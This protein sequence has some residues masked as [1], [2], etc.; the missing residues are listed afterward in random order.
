M[1]TDK[2]TCTLDFNHLSSVFIFPDL[3]QNKKFNSCIGW[4][5]FPSNLLTIVVDLIDFNRDIFLS[6]INQTKVTY[7]IYL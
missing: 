3:F 6:K 1:K 7:I 5:F 2:L 4:I